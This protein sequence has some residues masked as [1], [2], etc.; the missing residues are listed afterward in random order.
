[1]VTRLWAFRL[2]SLVIDLSYI[3]ERCRSVT[4][5]PL[6]PIQVKGNNLILDVL[7]KQQ[8]SISTLSQTFK[9]L[10]YVNSGLASWIAYLDKRYILNSTVFGPP[11]NLD[12]SD[13][14]RLADDVSQWRSS[15]LIVYEQ[16]GTV[17]IKGDSVDS[18]FSE[19]ILSKLD[20]M[21][22]KDLW[23]A[24]TCVLHLLPTPAAMISFRVAENIIRKYY[25]RVTGNSASEK[26]WSQLLLEMEQ[27]KLLKSSTLGY[28][29]FLKEKRNEAEHPDK[30]FTQEESERI[31]LNV[32]DLLDELSNRD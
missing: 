3:Y 19:P 30:R 10:Q 23:D 32:K 26:M 8:W 2:M 16:E 20:E 12:S 27:Q 29:R 1:L 24:I 13:A 5:V 4:L 28:L 11:I 31:L 15:I 21:A 18:V 6:Q 14:K 17:F 22:K 7:M 9:E 25:E